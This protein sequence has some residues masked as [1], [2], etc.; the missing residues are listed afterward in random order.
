MLICNCP[1]VYSLLAFKSNLF[2]LDRLTNSFIHVDKKGSLKRRMSKGM[3]SFRKQIHH[4]LQSLRLKRKESEDFS[5]S[6]KR[7]RSPK[8]AAAPQ[9]PQIIHHVN[10]LSQEETKTMQK[11]SETNI[12]V[13]SPKRFPPKPLPRQS[14][15]Q[16]IEP[17][18]KLDNLS[19]SSSEE[20]ENE[21]SFNTTRHESRAEENDQNKN[22]IVVVE[23]RDDNNEFDSSSEENNS[24]L[25]ENEENECTDIDDEE[26]NEG[27]RISESE[28]EDRDENQKAPDTEDEQASLWDSEEDREIE[29]SDV[30]EI[31]QIHKEPEEIKLK[32]PTPGTKIADLTNIIET[33]LH[34][35]SVPKPS[36]GVDPLQAAMD[37]VDPVNVLEI[38]EDIVE[39]E[40]G[41]QSMTDLSTNT[42]GTSMW[43]DNG[44]F[45]TSRPG[46]AGTL[47][48]LA[49]SRPGSGARLERGLQPPVPR[50]R[51]TSWD[52]D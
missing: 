8:K 11:G 1:K 14:K 33:Q 3:S 27:T 34:R 7:K 13:P 49:N 32:R 2:Q 40:L 23:N 15:Q 18:Q 42:L 24:D 22:T 17:Q 31:V 29:D 28:K 37:G 6:K 44:S 19:S 51:I 16:I 20:D 41:R 46:S 21:V 43:G 4:S 36:G 38:K 5:N 26:M 39:E 50:P 12:Y 30:E 10:E 48:S 52:S 45:H 35:R 25:Q 47:Q 9:P